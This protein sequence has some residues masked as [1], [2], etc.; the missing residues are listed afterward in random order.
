[1]GNRMGN[2]MGNQIGNQ[3]GI[4]MRNQMG[5][6]MGI[7]TGIQMG[8]QM[9]NQLGQQ[10]RQQLGNQ[11]GNHLGNTTPSAPRTPTLTPR[12]KPVRRLLFP[13]APVSG[14]RMRPFSPIRQVA[15][16]ATRPPGRYAPYD[17][18]MRP[19]LHPGGHPGHIV[20]LALCFVGVCVSTSW[21]DS[22]LNPGTDLR[23]G[24]PGKCWVA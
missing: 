12:T 8:N 18:T 1:M 21:S 17:A 7:Q 24:K 22:R 3:I 9:G 6:Q 16:S 19:G 4:Q 15:G 20:S 13:D 2:H 5:D 11:P 14:P 23:P 10:F